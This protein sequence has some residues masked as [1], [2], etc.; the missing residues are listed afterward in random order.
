MVTDKLNLSITAIKSLNKEGKLIMSLCCTFAEN[1]K[2]NENKTMLFV[3]RE[4]CCF[5]RLV[6]ISPN[7]KEVYRT[8]PVCAFAAGDAKHVNYGYVFGFVFFLPFQNF[9]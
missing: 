6:L 4:G 3:L 7:A 1:V 9:L 2:C 5:V 8:H